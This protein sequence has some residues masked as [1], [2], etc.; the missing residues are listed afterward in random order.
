MGGVFNPKRGQKIKSDAGVLVDQAYLAHF[1]VAADDAVAAG[2]AGVMALTNLGAATQNIATG[3]TDPAAP[4]GLSITGNV[5][6]VAGNVTISG[7][8][9]SGESISEVIAL[10]GTSTVSGNK[11]FKEVEGVA[12]PVQTHT[13]AAQTETKQVTHK[14]DAAGTITLTLTAAGYAGDPVA[15]E[16]ELD[17]SAVVVA[18]LIVEALNAQE[19]FAEMFT[20]SNGETDTVTLTAVGPLAND[21][22]LSLAFVDTDTTGVTMG[23]S[24]NGTAGVPYDTVSVGWN[25]KLGLPYKLS[26]NTIIQGMTFLNNTREAVEPTVAVSATAIESNTIDLSTALN[27][28][29]VDVYLL[30]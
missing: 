8:N 23:A 17:D 20:A 19:D 13:P 16:V 12:L 9:Y 11:A 30:V 14:A 27:G 24:T 3:L 21:S 7:K 18:G 1:Q 28:N 25:D 2:A 26:H 5:S 29:Q 22:T 6:G 10:S 15:L 4:R